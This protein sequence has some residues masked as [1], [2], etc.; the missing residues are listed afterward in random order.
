VESDI[1]EAMAQ[2]LLL[3]TGWGP[4]SPQ[5]QIES[6]GVILVMSW[7]EPHFQG[8]KLAKSQRS[9]IL[10][11]DSFGK[12]AFS[13]QISMLSE[14]QIRDQLAERLSLLETGLELI[15]K[16][17][18]LPNPLGSKGFIDIL[19]RDLMGNRVIIELKRSNT[20]AR[21]ALHEIVKY[22]ALLISQ[23]GV[24]RSKIRCFV[25][26][27]DWHELLVPFADFKANAAYQ[28]EGFK[29][30][31]SSSTVDRA[32]K[33]VLP[34]LPSKVSLFHHHAI[35]LFG[36]E[37][38][39]NQAIDE[40][41]SAMDHCGAD[42]YLLAILDFGGPNPQVV[43]PYAIYV[44]P[45]KLPEK[46]E[47]RLMALVDEEYDDSDP[48]E[49]SSLMEQTF[50]LEIGELTTHFYDTDFTYEIGYPEKFTSLLYQGWC[51]KRIVRKGISEAAA[52]DEEVSRLI[53]GVEG[54]SEL[55]YIRTSSPHLALNWTEMLEGSGRCLE[56]NGHWK[57][58]FNWFCRSIA[59]E[60]ERAI[61][62]AAVYNPLNLL[63]SLFKLTR[64]DVGYL[65]QMEIVADTPVG[66]GFNALFGVLLWDGATIPS[67]F[68]ELMVELCGGLEQFLFH[69][70][71]GSAW[72]FDADLM[73]RHGF[74]YA[75]VRSRREGAIMI[76]EEVT[77]DGE[78]PIPSKVGEQQQ[79]AL[80][81][82]KA[83]PSY[84]I[85]LVTGFESI[86]IGL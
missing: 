68:R 85:D 13:R 2:Y 18:Q 75:L 39:R 36:A 32:E 59:K 17:F 20:T 41:R 8:L 79:T 71:G 72:H 31:V 40:L 5:F 50:H 43:Y 70:H 33:I 6:R 49:R 51:R 30:H 69:V 28:V 21:Q 7:R 25:V 45:L 62:S 52:D 24:V 29:L 65:P 9:G 19:A 35:F 48:A 57:D 67:S 80:D 63:Q 37:A 54:Q 42:S 74:R 84:M 10:A 64:G 58:G 12:S 82:L 3:R 83:A 76:T 78:G 46:V 15:Q 86:Q 22:T 81:F 60:D 16:E 53:A 11:S 73:N 14:A 55:R 77:V 23:H 1:R 56:G 26:S 27:I 34:A 66:P 4:Q 47:L 44:V 38:N 61:V